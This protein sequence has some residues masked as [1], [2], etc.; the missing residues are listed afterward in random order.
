MTEV[1]PW[2]TDP[3]FLVSDDGTVRGPSGWVI[4]VVPDKQGYRV[5][6]YRKPGGSRS[7]TSVHVMV[8][9]TFIGPRPPGAQAAHENGD[10]GRLPA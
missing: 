10:P 5:I 3:R 7:S 4:G 1:R 2:P 8:C 9:E 6:S